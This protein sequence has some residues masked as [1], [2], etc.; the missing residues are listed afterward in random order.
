[1]DIQRKIISYLYFGYLP[2]ADQT[3]DIGIDK[4]DINKKDTYKLFNEK[5]L[6][7]KGVES[8]KN[9]FADCLNNIDDYQ[10]RKHIVPISG[11]L[12]SRAIL[13]GLIDLG[14]K[15][16]IVTVTYG[17]PGTLDYE[18][19]NL[20]AKHAGT[21][22]ISLDLSNINITQQSLGWTYKSGAEWTQL[23]TS[24]YNHR[25]THKF[26]YEAV[27]W[28]GFMGDP[29]AGSHLQAQES[30]TWDLAVF[31]F[32]KRNQFSKNFNL[33]PPQFN[34]CDVL[35]QEPIY[36]TN[37]LN[38][39]EQLDFAIRQHSFIKP[40]VMAKGY[41]YIAPFTNQNWINFILNVPYEY[42]YNEYI[43]K[44]I[45]QEAYPDFFKLPVKNR[46]G[47]TLDDSGWK[48]YYI[49]IYIIN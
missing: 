6:V 2:I 45:L 38:F 32:A 34:P 49:Y 19:G 4:L 35:P 24:Y 33:L 44:K 10:N 37:L 22:H 21:K 17:T 7:Q 1:M 47:L 18:L 28:S 16:N 41:N 43:Y 20:V 23:F 26:G 13:A 5:E 42:R 30:S 14:L 8:L 29:L 36:D 48:L 40:T 12:D 9:G 31:E 46:M 11:G 25:I 3:I 15:D 39:D 27:Y